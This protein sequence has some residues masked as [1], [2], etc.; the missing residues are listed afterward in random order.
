MT[1]WNHSPWTD[2]GQLTLVI[3][4]DNPAQDAQGQTL[5]AWFARLKDDG[6]LDGALEFLAH[7]LPRYECVVWAAQALL[8]TGI[9]NRNDP[10]MIAVLRWIDS[11]DDTMRRTAGE[12]GDEAKKTTPAKLLCDAVFLSGGSLAPVE[13]P[14]VQPDPY[15]CARM[16][17]ISVVLGAH[18]LP[19]PDGAMRRALAIGEAMVSDH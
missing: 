15:L 2:A 11:P 1:A 4:P 5:P 9:A 10:L 3:D 13:F 18:T 16:A 7:A 6:D 19:D 14:A 8:E 17:A 12:A